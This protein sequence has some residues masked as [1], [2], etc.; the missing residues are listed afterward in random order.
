MAHMNVKLF[1]GTVLTREIRM[2]LNESHEWKQDQFISK[3]LVEV[4]LH[5]KNYIG[6][7]SQDQQLSLTKLKEEKDTICKE[8]ALYCPEYDLDSFKF[9]IFPQIFI[10]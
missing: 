4:H 9:Y 3:K 7:Y 5:D 2:L 1:V 6:H 8:L 10:S